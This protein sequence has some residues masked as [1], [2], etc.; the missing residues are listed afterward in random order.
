MQSVQLLFFDLQLIRDRPWEMSLIKT[1]SH[2]KEL[3][4]DR[5]NFSTIAQLT[6][7]DKSQSYT[8][9]ILLKYNLAAGVS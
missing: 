5:L 6:D 2:L 8:L 4:R 1:R 7:R 3:E 9:V